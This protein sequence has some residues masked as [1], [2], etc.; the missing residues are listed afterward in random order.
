MKL[1]TLYDIAVKKGMKEDQRSK[2][3]IEEELRKAKKEYAGKKG[4]DK[5]CFDKERLKNPYSDTRILNGSGKEE[6][7]TVMVGIDMEVA[8]LL[9]ADRLRDN[10]IE[11]DLVVSHHP[12]GKALAQLHRVMDIQPGLWKKYGLT[13]EV[14]FGIMKDRIGEVSRGLSAANHARPVDAAKLLGIPFMCIHTAADNCVTSYLQELFDSKKPATLK[15]LVNL[16]KRIPEYKQAMELD[17][18]PHI[19]VGEEKNKAGRIFVDMTGGTSGPGKLF[20]RMHQSG[21]NTMVGMHCKES[22][23]KIAKSEFINYVIAGHIS[24]DNLGLNLLFDEIEKK[25]KLN[26]IECSGF[27][28]IRRNR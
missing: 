13:D 2:K 14:A 17:A 22:S 25:E 7:R 11:I 26:F 9:L 6:V 27:K 4:I 23:Y 21:V 5:A 18:G 10:G 15:S 20:S 19:L 24:S 16:L 3:L 28:R 1:Q 12:E 8:E